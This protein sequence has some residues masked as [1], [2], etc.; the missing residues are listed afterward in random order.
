[1]SGETRTGGGSWEHEDTGTKLATMQLHLFAVK[2]FV[3][4]KRQEQITIG[5][6]SFNILDK[7]LNHIPKY[8]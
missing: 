1:M 4:V 2:E 6:I 5:R 7:I 3:Q 8:D